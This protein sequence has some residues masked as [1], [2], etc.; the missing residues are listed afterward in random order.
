MKKLIFIAVAVLMLSSCVRDNFITEIVEP[1]TFTE[2]FVVNQ[3]HWTLSTDDFG[4]IYFFREFTVP[5]LNRQVFDHGIMQAFM[6]YSV[7]GRSTL[8]PLPFTDF[9]GEWEEHFTVEFQIGRVIFI[10]KPSDQEAILPYA[11]SYEFLVRFLW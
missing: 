8:S 9:F 5:Q 10:L 3:N 11:D 2:T 1:L 4:N 7:A 6:F